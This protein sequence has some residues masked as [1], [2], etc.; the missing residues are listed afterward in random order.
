VVLLPTGEV[1]AT[2]G[3]SIGYQDQSA[4]P[5]PEIFNPFTNTWSTLSNATERETIPRNYHSVAL[6]M[7]DGRVWTAGSSKEHA[8]GV[9]SVEQRIE[10]FEPWYQ[11][12]KGR[13][14][15]TAVPN[16]WRTG[17]EFVVRSTQASDIVM[18][19]M[20]RCGSCIH[21][22]NSDQRFIGPKFEY[23]GDDILL[24]TA[25]P[26]GNIAPPGVYFLYT[27]NRGLP[28]EGVWL[29]LSSDPETSDEQAWDDLF[30]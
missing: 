5:W 28:S 6:L 8:P 25:P 10:V 20:V 15:I 18:A 11:H 4:V 1:L 7:P 24:V 2:G 17:E 21:A 13:P 26:N 16:R 19:A 12:R 22:F 23:K 3:V 9:Q 27:I 30:K 14:E 29:Y